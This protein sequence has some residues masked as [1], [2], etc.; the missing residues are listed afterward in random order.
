MVIAGAGGH[1]LEVFQSLVDQGVVESELLF[2]DEDISKKKS[3]PFPER[4]ICSLDHISEIFQK[5]SE[6]CLGV[7]NPIHRQNLELLLTKIG[8]TLKG[9][10]HPSAIF[11]QTHVFTF[12]DK[13]AFS[14]V[15]PN[16][17]LGKGVLVNVRAN[18]HHDCKVGEYTEIG[19][20]AMLL[21]G[22]TIGE[23]CRIG[24]GAVILPG[25][26]LGD[27]IIVGAGAVVTKD[28]FQAGAILK[29]VP[30]K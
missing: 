8:G 17:N 3:H 7:G 18:I 4:V 22:S 29:G 1:G 21:G 30:A 20:G 26:S 14:F 5:N 13:M 12:V 11:D 27:E 24:A 15:G 10:A 19:P 2:F 9:L 28:C 25:V 6:F 23:K 16:T